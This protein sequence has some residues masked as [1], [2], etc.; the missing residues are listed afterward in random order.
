[1][2][3][4]KGSAADAYL[5]GHLVSISEVENLTSMDR[6][7]PHLL[8]KLDREALKRAVESELWPRN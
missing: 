5:T 3:R 8:P 7:L 1:L 4:Q 6:A 2:A